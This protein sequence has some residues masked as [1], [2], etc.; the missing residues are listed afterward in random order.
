[1]HRPGS[2][3]RFRARSAPLPAGALL[4]GLALLLGACA[5][6]RLPVPD[7]PAVDRAALAADATWLA[8]DARQGRGLGSAGLDAT[9]EFLAR[10]FEAL[11]LRPAGAGGSYFQ[12]FE[13]P[14]AIGIERARLA[15]AGLDFARGDDFE[16]FLTSGSGVVESEVVFVG[17]GIRERALG[18][19]DYAELDVEGKVVLVLDYRPELP[20]FRDARVARH[21][22]RAAKIFAAR[23]RGAAAVLIAPSHPQLPGLPAGAGAETI[24]PG[25][26]DVGLPALAI[27]R[28]AAE[29]L[30]AAAP[31]PP[32]AA[33]QLALERGGA[34]TSSPLGIRARIDVSI[35]RRLGEVRN[36]VGLLP[37]HDARV[38]REAVVLGA[39]YD[40]LGLGG[41]GSL[42]PAGPGQIH[43]GADDNASGTAGLLELAR[44]LARGPAL[45]RSVVFVAFTGEEAGLAGSRHYAAHPALPLSDTVAMFNLDMIGRLADGGL[46]VFGTET[47]GAWPGLVRRADRGIGLHPELSEGAIGPSDQT[48]FATRGVPAVFFFTGLHDDYHRPSDDVERLDLDG[49]ARVVGLTY[50]VLRAVS[51]GRGNPVPPSRAGAQVA[52]HTRGYGAYLGT[53]PTFGGA[54]VRGVRLQAVQPGSPAAAAG[55]RA[56]DV[57]V[58]FAGSS[59][60]NLQELALLLARHRPGEEVEIVA[61]RGEQTHRMS[62]VLGHRR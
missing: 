45:R 4:V 40:H 35:E 53:V 61:R 51:D 48:P 27:S 1:M 14:V 25:S 29:R 34:P 5:V 41:Y 22:T 9:A 38:G 26:S 36:V 33:R 31:G 16:A 54:P 42:D 6:W 23:D 8:D 13:M 18:W 19:D 21:M 52:S 43:N 10:R 30:V 2:R 50:R 12:P 15:A 24:S 37:G 32:L 60:T 55:L 7:A 47:S 3:P 20:R 49:L 62:A 57:I 17:H 56:D 59:V 11:G 28:S 39:H 44:L 58:G 46:T